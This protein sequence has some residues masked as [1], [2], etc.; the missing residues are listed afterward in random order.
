NPVLITQKLLVEY[1]DT[2]GRSLLVLLLAALLLVYI[3]TL[4]GNLVIIIVVSATQHLRSSM[5][6]FLSQ[7]SSCDIILTTSI[8]PNLLR[9]TLKHGISMSVSQCIA[10][11][12]FFSFSGATEC[13]LLTMMSYD[14]YVAICKPLHYV[15]IMNFPFCL[16]LVVLSWILGFFLT[17]ILTS[18]LSNLTFCNSKYIDHF[19]C[20]LVPLVQ[21]SCSD[22]TVLQTVIYLIGVPETFIETVFIISTYVCIFLAIHRI[23]STTGRQKAF[24]TCS[25]HLAVVCTYYGTLIAIYVFPSGEYSSG[26][27]KIVSLM[28]TVVTP[29]LNPV[30]YNASAQFWSRD[31]NI[32]IQFTGTFSISRINFVSSILLVYIMTLIGNLLIIILFSVTPQLRSPMYFFLSQ[33]S[34]CDIILT[35]SIIPNLLHITLK[36]DIPMS[37]SQCIAQFNFFC[38]A[39]VTECLLLTMM[40]YDRYV[41][42]CKPLHYVTIMNFPF[43]LGLVVLSWTSGVLITMIFVILLSNLTFCDSKYIDHFFC[44]IDPLVQLPCSD[45]TVFQIVLFLIALP[46]TVIETVF[47]ISTYVCIF[48]TIHRIS[49]TTGRQ[50]A[51]STCSYHLAVVCTY[52]GTVIAIY[53]FP[54]GESSSGINKIVS[55]M[56]T[57]VTPLLNPLIYSLRNQEFKIMLKFGPKNQFLLTKCFC[58]CFRIIKYKISLFSTGFNYVWELQHRSKIIFFTTLLLV[59]IMTLMGNLVIIIVVSATQ[60]LRSPMY[61]FLSQLSSCDIILT[62]SIIP[63]LLRITLKNGIPISVSQCIAQFNF[64]SFSTATE[65]LLL[66]MMSYDR[67]VA[68]CKPVHYVTIMNIPF[69]F[70]LE[71]F[72]WILGFLLTLILTILLSNLTFCISKYIDHFF[73]DLV[74]LVQLSCSDTTVLQT[75]IYLIGVP[76]TFIET[77]FII[78]TYVCI[79]LAIHRISSTTGRQKAF[80]TCSSHLAV[81]CM[82]YG[83]FIAIYIFPSRESSSG[84]N[85]IVSLIYTVVTPLLNPVIYSLRNQEIKTH[86]LLQTF[87]VVTRC[88]WMTKHAEATGH[89]RLREPFLRPNHSEPLLCVMGVHFVLTFVNWMPLKIYGVNLQHRSKIILFT[90]L[91]LIYIMTLMGNLVI[92]IVVS[93][94]Q[95]LR[96]PMY[97]FLSQLSSCDIILTTTIIPN[98]LR[99]TLKNGIPISVSQ[100][101]AQFNF[102]SSSSVTEC[103]LLTMMSYDRYVAVCKPLHYVTIMNIP[104]CFSLVVLSWILGFLLALIFVILLS[105]STFCNSEYIDHFFCDLVPLVQLSCSDTTVLQTVLI[106]VAV[107]E[108]VIETVFIISTYVCIFLAIHR[109]S[110]TIGRQKAFSTCSSH[111]AVVCMY[112]GTFI[113][114]YIFPSRESSSGI[115]KIVSLMY[116]VVTPLLN[117]VIYSLRNQEIKTLQPPRAPLRAP[118]DPRHC[119]QQHIDE[120]LLLG[121]QLERRSKIILFSTLLLVYIMTLMGNLLIIILVSTTQYLRSPMYFFLSQLSSCDI[122][123]TTSIIPNLLYITLKNGI[124]MSVS[125]CIAQ[126]NFFSSSSVT[127]CFLLT[128][129]SYDRYVAVCKPLHYVTIMNFPFCLSLVVLSWILGYLLTL[130]FSILLSNL[131]FCNS[132]YIDHFFCD[133]VPLVQLSCSDTTVLQTVLI[134]IV[135]PQTVSETVFI[136]A[137]YVCIFVAVQRISSKT[138][139]EKAFSTCSSHL[140]VVCTYYG[141]L[142]AIYVFPSGKYSFGMNKIVSLMYT[143]V[144]PLL[145]PVIYSLRNQEIKTAILRFFTSCMCLL[146]FDLSGLKEG[147]SQISDSGFFLLG[148]QLLHRSRII[149][150]STLLLVYIM[151]LTGN[152]LIIIL[153]SATQYL[154]SPMYFFLSQLSSCDII[155]TT[156]I[157]PPLLHITLQNGIYISVSQCIAQFNFFSVS[158]GTECF[159]LAMMSYDRYVAV[160]KPL[161]YVIIMNF[162]FC[163]SLVVLSWILGFLLTLVMTS[164]LSN[165]TFCNSNYID[166]FFCDI[167]PFIQLSCSDTTVLQAVIYLTGIP[168]TVIETVFIIST[169]VCIFLAIHRISSTTGRQKAF[170]TC[171]SHLTVVCTYYGTLIAIYVF[172]S[173]EHSFGINKILSLMYTVVTPLLNP[174][175]YSLRNQEIKTAFIKLL[176]KRDNC[177]GR[178]EEEKYEDQ[179]YPQRNSQAWDLM[180][181]LH[182]YNMIPRNNQSRIILFSILLLVYIMTLTGNL[183]IIILVSA[184]QYLCSPMY[185]FL[186]QLS[187]CD[188]ILTTSIIPNLLHVTLHNGI[189]MSVSQCIAQFSFFCFPSGTECLLLTI[190]SYDR[191]VAVCKPLHYVTI[192]NFPFCLGL[193]V[194]SWTLGVLITMILVILLSNLTFCNSEYI[195]NFFCDIDPLVQLSCSDTTVLQ[196]VI[197]LIGVP[198]T[199]I[200]TVFIISTYVCI[201]LAMHRI[202]STTGRQKAF[203]T[204]SSHLAV[205]CTYYGTV[206]AIYVFPS[207]EHASGINKIVS[208]MYTVVTPFLNPVIYSLRNQEIK[209]AI[210]K[211]N[212][213]RRVLAEVRSAGIEVVR[214]IKEGEVRLVVFRDE[215][216]LLGFQ[217]LHR[218]RIIIFSILLL[219]YIMTLTGNLLIIILVS[220]TQYLHSPM[221]LFLSQLSSCDI[222]LSTSILPNLLHITLNNGIPVSVSQCIAQFNF[223]SFS[224]GTECIFL[225][226]MSYDRYVAVCKPLHYVTIMNF[227]FCLSLV[228]LSWILGFLL[229]LIVSILLSDL[230]FCSAKYIDHFFCDLVPLV[231]LSCSDTT[232]LQTMIFLIGVPETLIETVFIISTYVCI[233]LAIHRISST[234]GRQKAFSTCSSHLAVVCMYYGTIIAIYVFPSGE[235]SSGI[236][237]IVSLMYTVVTPLLNPVIYSLRNQD[238]KTAIIKSHEARYMKYEL[239]KAGQKCTPKVSVMSLFDVC[240]KSSQEMLTFAA[241]GA[242][243]YF[244]LGKRIRHCLKGENTAIQWFQLPHRS[245]IIIFSILLLAYIMTLTG[246]LLIII[247]VSA[248]QYLHSPMYLFLSQLSSCDII[249]ST[250]IIPNLLHITLKNGILMPVS[251]CIAQFNFFSFSGGTECIFLTVM[252]YDRYVAICKPLHYVTIMNF[253]FC[254]SLVVLSWILGFLLTLTLTILL[255]N[256]TFCISKYIDHFF[257]DLVPLVQL[258]CSDT[259]V[260]QTMIFLIGVPETVIETVFI[261]STYVCIFL[262][263]HRISSTTG[264]QKAFSTCSSHLAVVCMYYGTIIAIYVFPSGEYS[265]GISKIVSLMYTV[266]TPLLNPVIYSLRNQDIKTAIIKRH[267]KVRIRGWVRRF[268]P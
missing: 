211:V 36:N 56:Y 47:I 242:N 97:F 210:I 166:H 53:A 63:N 68:V 67:Y 151:T 60:Y 148:F 103:L 83:T 201:F 25:S 187:S 74:P 255:S 76:E 12:N 61:F 153:V 85:K 236:S 208:L 186:S 58:H 263:I 27:N 156:T 1:K 192:M 140:S 120:F 117:P 253:P 157:L 167:V 177:P 40:S 38:F 168:E 234:T 4:M 169:Y 3:M 237:K 171:S 66:T 112:Y 149:L 144:T 24:S 81:V 173:G 198:E 126:F 215:F 264:R 218:S 75:I 261:I 235:Y 243:I 109:I 65:C 227:P 250:S 137:T 84:I 246:N 262:A 240:Y 82:Y 248:T 110:S 197:Y 101:I 154:R 185:L 200:E 260:L 212:G 224:G 143:V 22:T 6:F 204:C 54:S 51:S 79:F 159:L 252:S 196:T 190:M 43:C 257:C 139:R 125:Q 133:L 241:C 161:H 199:V 244:L 155:L 70:S 209:T 20:D 92:I 17:L 145:N 113:A 175:I 41:A 105:N 249:L 49:T 98:L 111:L 15:T 13:F 7:L 222:I 194:L 183:L 18:L 245:R 9:I 247:L 94:T 226:M 26:I 16:S 266:V 127:E 213:R 160:C 11:F 176:K 77:V 128:V 62:T 119:T 104:F 220:A 37:V 188:I 78:S 14:R 102:F 10:Q 124:S 138:R 267:W 228:V 141:T 193:V 32:A 30:I 136:I 134:V 251:Q 172:P 229:T 170:S 221:Y 52:Y 195:D 207:G 238:I 100:C 34:S 90:T 130:I 202:S 71:V 225:T 108:T 230:T 88:H 121:F 129:M 122:I 106:L 162:P 19:F 258:S 5:Y 216:F 64:F 259:T 8:I 165:L 45:T 69:C 99:I 132:N 150:F 214:V 164:F 55:L 147:K 87:Q 123:L 80:S 59:Y 182:Q 205:V 44:D 180:N 93:A 107:P 23:S 181:I 29:L 174:V 135:V 189:P 219:V 21:L 163:L 184:T 48:F 114:I 239:S 50:K 265:S 31:G 178:F 46:E 116:T 254:L 217:L 142:F 233:F 268:G 191:Y 72:S 115:N 86:N 95:Y 35:T 91:L 146:R 152:L 118:C 42:V 231:Q 57:V 28:Y 158:V 256:L 232:V 179:L 39:S 2:D 223:V 33:L 96:S 131:T 73:C 89:D 203:S 206:I